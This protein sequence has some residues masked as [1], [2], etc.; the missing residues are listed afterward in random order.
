MNDNK[1]IINKAKLIPV[2][3]FNNNNNK[4]IKDAW[5]DWLKTR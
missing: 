1:K 2:P 5:N 3:F 4:K